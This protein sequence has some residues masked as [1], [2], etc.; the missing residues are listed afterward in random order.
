MLAFKHR[1][2]LCGHLRMARKKHEKYNSRH[3]RET[4]DAGHDCEAIDRLQDREA[5]DRLHDCE[6]IDVSRRAFLRGMRWAPVLFLPARIQAL[7]FRSAL[8]QP[9]GDRSAAFPFADFRLTPHYPA[10]SPL[11]DVLRQVVPGGDA[12]ITEKY[13]FEIMRLL[14]AWSQALKA[15]P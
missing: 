12:Y 8:P 4:N 9:Q 5:I 13:A 14:G 15:A 7:P 10:T 2:V 11:D 1:L 6:A 3:A